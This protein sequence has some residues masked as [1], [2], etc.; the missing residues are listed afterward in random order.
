MYYAF[1]DRENL[2]LLM[3]LVNGGDLRFHIGR[4]KKF[5]ENQTCSKKT[6]K[7]FFFNFFV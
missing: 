2:Y 4:Q 3:D 6:Q 5:K 7:I 1:Q